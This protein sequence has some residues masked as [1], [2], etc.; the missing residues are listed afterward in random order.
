MAS[1]P[2]AHP[3]G[4]SGSEGR[5]RTGFLRAKRPRGGR[6]RPG[7]KAMRRRCARGRAIH[8]AGSAPAGSVR[9]GME[10]DGK[11]LLTGSRYGQ[12][13]RL[14]IT[15]AFLL[16]ALPASAQQVSGP[17]ARPTGIRSISAEFRCGFSGS[18]RPS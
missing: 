14:T 7:K 8:L 16:F 15:A 1:G 9:A 17:P 5:R 4:R 11:D 6:K 10:M 3:K 18:M 2:L 12:R 13:M